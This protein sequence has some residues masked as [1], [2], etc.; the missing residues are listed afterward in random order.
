MSEN[1]LN[2]EEFVFFLFS[3]FSLGLFLNVK[4][5]NQNKTADVP[6]IL[7]LYLQP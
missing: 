5:A 7:N 4:L 2:V 3:K 1:A 6:V